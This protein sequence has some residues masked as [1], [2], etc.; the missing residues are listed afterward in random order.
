MK[1]SIQSYL[2]YK[3]KI[4]FERINDVLLGNIARK[5]DPEDIIE[6]MKLVFLVVLNSPQKEQF[7]RKIM[8]LD[9]KFQ[10]SLMLFIKKILNHDQEEL[11]IESGIQTKEIENLKNTKKNLLSQISE[12]QKELTN[13]LN[14]K[15]AY[16]KEN[17]ELKF[18]NAQ[19]QDE[20]DNMVSKLSNTSTDMY[21]K[22]E[23]K[24]NEKTQMLEMSK[25]ILESTRREL[26]DEISKLKDELDIALADRHKLMYLEANLEKYKR[27]IETL[28][29][30]K[31]KYKGLKKDN[32][33]M[34]QL[35]K[36]HQYDSEY[37]NRAKSKIKQLKQDLVKEK[38]QI[39]MLQISID[40]KEKQNRQLQS[41]IVELKEKIRF[42]ENY[43]EELKERGSN[44][45]VSS[46]SNPS[47]P[48][49]ND[50]EYN[51]MK[52]IH[53]Q[54]MGASSRSD[55]TENL[56]KENKRLRYSLEMSL[57]KK[58]EKK[59]SFYMLYEELIIREFS[60]SYK[61]FQLTQHNEVMAA[62]IEEYSDE[63][64][65]IEGERQNFQVIKFEVE[66]L[67]QKN[68]DLVN[69]IKKSH[70]DKDEVFMRCIEA[71]DQLMDAKGK[72]NEKEMIVHQLNLE[73][74]I[75]KEQIKMQEEQIES[76][77]LKLDS[78]ESSPVKINLQVSALEQEVMKL[79][80]VNSDLESEKVR[81]QEEN[82]E[83]LRMMKKVHEETV[84]KLKHEKNFQSEL[85]MR[86]T[87]EA[88]SRIQNDK[89]QIQAKLN[90]ER[91][92]STRTIRNTMMIRDPYV[93]SIDEIK[94]LKA[95]LSEQLEEN[96]KLSRDNQE[97]LICW[98]ESTLM[99]KQLKRS[100]DTEAKRMQ[101]IVKIRQTRNSRL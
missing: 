38:N 5:A 47:N 63:R 79:R 35:I 61:I 22:L 49:E 16:Q 7:V 10:I 28:L 54:S 17:E 30:F 51:K 40:C 32:E 96:E 39:D 21:S 26:Q 33:Q 42:L 60:N 23:K 20:L 6:L 24:L 100:I 12:Q 72:L 74:K 56:I 14:S 85:L 9:E 87:E 65:E 31:K 52:I 66:N 29:D 46:E 4:P 84:E 45:S 70:A 3:V 83:N 15:E 90:F 64:A 19:L 97:L 13:A 76:L 92:K 69:T 25:Q 101:D 88:I 2:T 37:T 11:S 53:M 41:N 78:S 34:Q 50:L 98:K 80:I 71:K 94:R 89:E 44:S 58:R 55:C 57:E 18:A 86:D 93:A 82:Q 73:L 67:K 91:R 1:Q 8:M 27:K 43:V 68:E 99:L 95:Q 62:R 77:K 75:A 59:E 81:I 36:K 48:T